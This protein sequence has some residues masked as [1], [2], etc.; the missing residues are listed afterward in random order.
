MQSDPDGV[1]K[2]CDWPVNHADLCAR[3]KVL[4]DVGPQLL[5]RLQAD[6]AYF[7]ATLAGYWIWGMCS[8]IGAGLTRINAR[9]NLGDAGKGVH[10]I[11][12]RPHLGDAG[13]GV[14]EL[15]VPAIYDWFRDLSERLRHVRV[16]CG[17]WS[18]VCGGDWQD[19]LG[20]CGYFFDPPYTHS[21]G[22]D[23]NC[24]E[25][26]HPTVAQDVATWALDRGSRETYRIA[27]CGYEGEHP[28]LESA[29]WDI[30]SWKAQGGM[31]SLGKGNGTRGEINAHRERIWFSPHCVKPKKERTIF[32]FIA[33]CK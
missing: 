23:P 14:Q 17:D 4:Q 31:A 5:E 21:M 12:R 26:D 29:G 27:I 24:Y 8:W 22:R 25:T 18:R 1:A 16:V 10:A 2:I 19:N 32:D 20:I 33:E 11:S 30:F 3:R 7:D 9:P 6:P 13:R 28:R 15:Y